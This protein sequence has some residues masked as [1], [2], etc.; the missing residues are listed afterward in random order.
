MLATTFSI[1]LF[2]NSFLAASLDSSSALAVTSAL[3][4]ANVLNSVVSAANSSFNSGNSLTFTS[5][6]LTLKTTGFPAKFSAWYSS[7]KVTLTS[8]SSPAFLPTNCSSNPGM[9]DPEPITKSYFSPFPPSKA[10]SPSNPSKSMLA[11]S[12]L[13][14]SLSTDTTLKV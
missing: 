11:V 5:F 2:L 14:I 12:P 7:G 9:K 8:T 10:T 3:N 1:T 6:T 4:S 13:A